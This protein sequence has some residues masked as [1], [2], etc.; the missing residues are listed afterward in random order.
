VKIRKEIFLTSLTFFVLI[1]SLPVFAGLSIQSLGLPDSFPVSSESYTI[2]S[3]DLQSE[4]TGFL[5]FRVTSPHA[6][7]EVDGLVPF[8]KLLHEIE[9]IEQIRKD[10]DGNEFVGGAVDSVKATGKGMVTLVGHPIQSAKGIGQATGKLSHKIGG[11]F[12]KKEEGEKTTFGEKMLGGSEREVAKELGVDVYTTN[13]YLAA[14]LGK[15]ARA[16][17]GGK[18]AAVIT[19]LLLP[20]AGLASMAMTAGGINSAADQL[21]NDKGR[22]DLFELN[23]KSLL[24]M[25]FDPE[26]AMKLLNL[27]YYSP[28]EATYIRFY[29][30]RLKGVPGTEQIFQK[31]LQAESLWEA[32]EILYEAE[33]AANA[34]SEKL[35]YTKIQFFESGLAAE[36]S[37]RIIFITPYDWLD[38]SELGNRIVDGA[39]G[40]KKEASKGKAEIWNAGKITTG[41]SLASLTKGITTKAWVLFQKTAPESELSDITPGAQA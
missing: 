6:P 32:R 15:M 13:P 24:A 7:Y 23:Q 11:I 12:R 8:K 14:L 21:V 39:L 25:G 5:K 28:R 40:A 3:V 19:K 20:V 27:P 38:Q 18:G 22:G 31:A 34:M 41:F 10:E 1:V 16:R 29:L 17:L 2:D 9:V 36:T 4:E 37:D 26:E 35:K 30:E 33:I